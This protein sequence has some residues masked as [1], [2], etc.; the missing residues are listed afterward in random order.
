MKPVA[1][2]AAPPFQAE[3]EV[4]YLPPLEER[5]GSTARALAADAAD[6][7]EVRSAGGHPYQFPPEIVRFV[8]EGMDWQTVERVLWPALCARAVAMKP[9]PV[10]E[11]TE[12][13]CL[14]IALYC[15]DVGV[16]EDDIQV[17]P[18]AEKISNWAIAQGLADAD[19][20]AR[21]RN[22]AFRHHVRRLMQLRHELRKAADHG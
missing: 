3:I 12:T 20:I 13:R 17:G 18:L 7:R 14:L 10:S 11:I 15:E 2:P 4:R 6:W 8:A 22:T 5:D 16:S 1:P 21:P 9:S 19:L